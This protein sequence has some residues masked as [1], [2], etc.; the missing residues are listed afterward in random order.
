MLRSFT[1]REDKMHQ[2]FK[3]IIYPERRKIN[4]EIYVLKKVQDNTIEQTPILWTHQVKDGLYLHRP[5]TASAS[6]SQR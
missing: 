3:K 5:E 4:N 2:K 6:E 1:H